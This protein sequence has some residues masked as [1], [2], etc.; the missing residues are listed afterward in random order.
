MTTVPPHNRNR[1]HLRLTYIGFDGVGFDLLDESGERL[2]TVRAEVGSGA[3]WRRAVIFPD[4]LRSAE[5]LST[6]NDRLDR[7]IRERAADELVR[8]E[9]ATA[10][11][12]AL[13]AAA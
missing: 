7:E 12:A 9:A 2:R 10:A 4:G 13:R 3:S 1:K 5:S 8:L 6:G 11:S